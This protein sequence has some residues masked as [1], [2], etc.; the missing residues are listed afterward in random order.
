MECINNAGY[1][2]I[3][4]FPLNSDYGLLRPIK[5]YEYEMFMK[6]VNFLKKTSKNIKA[7]FLNEMMKTNDNKDSIK[8]FRDLLIN[9][10]MVIFMHQNYFETKVFIEDLI[11][12][13]FVDNEELD[14]ETVFINA[15][16]SDKEWDKFRK[17]VLAFNGIVTK[18]ESG[19]AE[20]QRFNNLS[21][22]LKESKGDSI[23]YES[24]YS[25]IMAFNG[26]RP[27][28]INNLTIYQFNAL[29]HRIMAIKN[30]DTSVLFKT[31]DSKGTVKITSFATPKEDKL[32]DNEFV[33]LTSLSDK[34]DI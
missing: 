13:A 27:D 5:V 26:Y 31:V 3:N 16:K 23:N 22:A 9:N 25:T 14:V 4:G 34:Q 21:N 32:K 11:R 29:F 18:D 15:T 8:E 24:T 33:K 20:I 6:Y 2:K 28:E 1:L 10:E 7:L 12:L 19:D 30:Y 17:Y